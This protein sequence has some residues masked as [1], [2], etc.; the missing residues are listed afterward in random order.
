VGEGVKQDYLDFGK[1]FLGFFGTQNP[2]KTFLNQENPDSYWYE[3]TRRS[4]KNPR[5]RL[6]RARSGGDYLPGDG[7]CASLG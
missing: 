5:Q 2:K 3:R 7:E 4:P 1:D 6:G